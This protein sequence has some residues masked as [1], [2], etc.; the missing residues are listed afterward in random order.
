[1]KI[2]QIFTSVIEDI[3]SNIGEKVEELTI[4]NW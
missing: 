2:F 3:R 4:I 1:M